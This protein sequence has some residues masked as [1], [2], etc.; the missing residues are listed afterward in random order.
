MREKLSYGRADAI[1]TKYILGAGCWGK[2]SSKIFDLNVVDLNL[3]LTHK[4]GNEAV[5]APCYNPLTMQPAQSG[6]RGA[7][8]T[9]TFE[10]HDK[11]S[12][13]RLA[14]S[15]FCDPSACR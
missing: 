15:Y 6:G 11:G 14:L 13:T 2:D 1:V 12:R 5:V 8:P 9:S 10:R 4:S 3:V 7:N